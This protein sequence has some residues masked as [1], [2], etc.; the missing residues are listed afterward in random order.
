MVGMGEDTIIMA[1]EV[2]GAGTAV[3]M[4]DIDKL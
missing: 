2:M 1:E 3:V 4:A